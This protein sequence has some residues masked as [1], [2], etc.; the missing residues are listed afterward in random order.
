MGDTQ[1]HY[2]AQR[3]RAARL[4]WERAWS[5]WDVEDIARVFE[6]PLAWAE[7]AIESEYPDGDELVMLR[8]A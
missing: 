5:Y 6:R 7:F 8:D 1:S 2:E 4:V 3:G